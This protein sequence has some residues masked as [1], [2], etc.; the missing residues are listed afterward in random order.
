VLTGW[1]DLSGLIADGPPGPPAPTVRDALRDA[2]APPAARAWRALARPEQLAVADS[3]SAY[4][5]FLAGRGTGKTWTASNTLVEWALREPGFYAVVAPTFSDVRA[6]CVEGPS[7]LLYA[8]GAPNG[9]PGGE[10]RR[11]DRSKHE[12]HLRNGAVLVM[13]SDE[14]PKRLRGP[15]YTGCW[16]EE[17]AS[18]RNVRESW[19]EGVLFS[20]RIGSA[21]KLLTGTP[22]RGHPIV[23][24]FH[25]RGLR[26]DPDVTLIRG[27]TLDNA[28][29][30]SPEFL[31]TIR[32]R[33][34]GTSLGRQEL[35]GLLLVDA[36]G[37]LMTTAL[38]DATRCPPEFVPELRRV[39]VA[40][41]PAVTSR[42]DSDH[43][44]IVVVGLG[45]PP[46][47]GYLGERSRAD[48]W[49]LY[50]LADESV[51]ATPRS[52]AER[53]LKTA[54][55]WAADGI[56][57]EINQGHDLVTTMITMV[58]EA[59]GLPL[60]HLMPVHAAVGKRARAEPFAGLFE[61]RRAHIVGGLPAVE[62][63][64][65]GWTPGDVDSPDQ[66]DACVWGGVGLLPQL[67]VGRA[68]RV[69]ILV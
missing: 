56:V 5:L 1:T 26:G 35:D 64:L 58:A 23:R 25:D 33:Y 11:Y 18:W 63:Q 31:R 37:A 12:L 7:G 49:H 69:A 42:P 57:A 60:P 50:V 27:R 29:N 4:T 30:L 8:L 32:A 66:L 68:T 43:T 44:G 52:W 51:Q 20:T 28:S 47:S 17:I 61:Q 3:R 15:N 13:G 24:E 16:A 21:R 54:E 34:E 36:E 39:L 59:S 62:D 65:A 19:E 9:E 55:Q 38:L 48:G 40:V 22:K 67:G 45:G 6:F 53:V 2:L 41:D 46:L 10:L 14:A